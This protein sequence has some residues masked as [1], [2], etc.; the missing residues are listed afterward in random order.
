VATKQRWTV[1]FQQMS[2]T[3][4]KVAMFRS[5]RHC[6]AVTRKQWIAVVILLNFSRRMAVK[7]FAKLSLSVN[8]SASTSAV[9]ALINHSTEYA[10][11]SAKGL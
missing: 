1:V 8:I 4:K 2:F 5:K 10:R 9:S 6:L 11:K 7:R 3:A